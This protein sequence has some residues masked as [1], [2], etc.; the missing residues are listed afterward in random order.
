MWKKEDFINSESAYAFISDLM[1][2]GYRTPGGKEPVL[3]P[4]FAGVSWGE[5][6]EG[7]LLFY[8]NSRNCF[9]GY[10]GATTKQKKAA[11]EAAA[12]ERIDTRDRRMKELGLSN[13]TNNEGLSCPIHTIHWPTKAK[14]ATLDQHGNLLFFQGKRPQYNPE[15]GWEGDVISGKRM[16]C[17]GNSKHIWR[18]KVKNQ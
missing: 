12:Q 10:G 11:K 8:T 4:G 15:K 6:K 17:E 2:R 13:V 1:Q 14:Y 7:K 18:K 3:R 9:A 16:S 5:T